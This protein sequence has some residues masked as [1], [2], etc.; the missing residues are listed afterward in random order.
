MLK[1]A[2]RCRALVALRIQALTTIS[3]T[4]PE[5]SWAWP[6]SE[7]LPVG[8]NIGEPLRSQELSSLA[9]PSRTS[10]NGRPPQQPFS[11]TS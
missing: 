2:P 7:A 5:L 3:S 8:L 6:R 1:L 11:L 9:R 4:L 10:G